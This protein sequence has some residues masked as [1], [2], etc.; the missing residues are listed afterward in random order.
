MP[1]IAVV[2]IRMGREKGAGL[3]QG[4]REVGAE[5]GSGPAMARLRERGVAGPEDSVAGEDPFRES[6]CEGVAQREGDLHPGQQRLG[7]EGHG[8]IKIREGSPQKGPAAGLRHFDQET[9]LATVK[10]LR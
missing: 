3:L 4:C 6:R 7:Q 2:E 5:I 1:H 9:D 10:T 8:Y